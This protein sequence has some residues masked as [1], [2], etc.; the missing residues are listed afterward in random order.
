[1]SKRVIELIRVSTEGQA[2]EDRAGIP[3]QREINRR[4]ASAFG[5]TIF[6]TIEIVDVSGASVLASPEMQQLLRLMESAEIHGVVTKEFSRLMRPEKFTDYALLQHFIDTGTVLYLPDGP[7]DLR[8][9]TGRFIGTIRAAVAGL[10]R[11]EI[12]ERMQDAK[13]AMRRAGKHAGG[14][15]SLP[16]GV[17]YSKERGWH[18]TAEA[19]KVKEAFSLFLS[20]ETSYLEIG[21]KLNIPRTS[22]RFILENPIYTGWRTYDE[23]RDPSV[24]GYVAGPNGRQGYRKKIARSPEEVI[25]VRVFDGFLTEEDFNRVQNVIELK[26]KKHWRSRREMPN[27]YTYNGFLTCGDCCQ[28]LYTHSSKNDFYICKTRHTRE[29]RLRALQG[30]EPCANKYMLRSKLEAKID[31]LLGTQLVKPEFLETV[32]DQ[33]NLNRQSPSE[34]QIDEQAVKEKLSALTAKSER[35]LDAFLDGVIGRKQ[36]DGLLEYTE[37]EAAAYSKLLMDSASPLKPNPIESVGTILSVVQPFAEWEFLSR[38]ERRKLLT[39]LCP[40]I[41]VDRYKIKCLTLKLKAESEDRS[42]VSHSKTAR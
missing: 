28:P 14:T 31:Q 23:K 4:T 36:R 33:Y 29:R 3:A 7:I 39:L 38:D 30:L 22:V 17:G 8:S 21:R 11:R 12:V 15:S 19:E 20:G 37:R 6:K 25:R 41:A 42:E 16:F 34:P 40:E 27:R 9:K 10:E 32:L 2:A 1:M 24:S 5:L 13:E 26:R 35:I 18:L